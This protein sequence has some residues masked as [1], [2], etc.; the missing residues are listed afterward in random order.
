MK[1]GGP[2]TDLDGISAWMAVCEDGLTLLE[3][4][5]MQPLVRISYESVVTFGGCQE[6]FMV[7]LST[8]EGPAGTQKMLFAL[9]KPRVSFFSIYIYFHSDV[10]NL[11]NITRLLSFF[12]FQ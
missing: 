3:T 1:L 4:G 8:E 10:C 11:W 6:D 12:Y 9:P 2:F 5:A 7:V